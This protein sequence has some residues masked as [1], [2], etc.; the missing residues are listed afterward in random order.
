LS[1]QD[2]DIYKN[3]N[4]VISER[5][6]QEIADTIFELVNTDTDKHEMKKRTK[7]K[8]KIDDDKGEAVRR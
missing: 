2:Q 3:F 6:Q 8:I 1:E 5:W 4:I 7:L